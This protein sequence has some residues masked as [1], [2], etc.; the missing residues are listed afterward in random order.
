MIEND[1]VHETEKQVSGDGNTSRLGV[2]FCGLRLNTPLVLL[3]GCVGFGEEYTRVEGFSNRQVGAVCLKGTTLS[4]RLGNQPHRVWETPAGMLNSI[5]LQN[6]GSRH[7]VENILPELDFEETRFFANVS[8][9][10]LE[11]YVQVTRIFDEAYAAGQQ[12]QG[13]VRA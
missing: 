3:S 11:E 12:N 6:P 4:P 10:T 1:V 9:A 13:R 5:G 2:D 7:V 8:G